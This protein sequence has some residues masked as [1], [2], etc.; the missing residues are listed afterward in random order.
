MSRMASA[1]SANVLAWFYTG[2]DNRHAQGRSQSVL[3]LRSIEWTYEREHMLRIILGYN[4][5]SFM[6]IKFSK[7]ILAE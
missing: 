1:P 3:A 6:N 2:S 4:D 7:K 5:N